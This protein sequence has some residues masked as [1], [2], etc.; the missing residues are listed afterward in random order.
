[1]SKVRK[2]QLLLQNYEASIPEADGTLPSSYT[3][4]ELKRFKWIF[5]VKTQSMQLPV[6][7]SKTKDANNMSKNQ[8]QAENYYI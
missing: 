4:K 1:M 5:L 8:H 6:Y 7:H 2:S 3:Y